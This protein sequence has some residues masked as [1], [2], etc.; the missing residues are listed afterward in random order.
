M[1]GKRGDQAAAPILLATR[2]LIDIMPRNPLKFPRGRHKRDEL[3][4]Y[5]DTV[6][7]LI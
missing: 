5:P 4:R 2:Q 7:V 3:F 1:R 6:S